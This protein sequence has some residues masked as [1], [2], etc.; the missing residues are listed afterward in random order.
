MPFGLD[1]GAG[2]LVASAGSPRGQGHSRRV[3]CG[4][5]PASRSRVDEVV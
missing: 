2:S 1:Q 3:G 4:F 5:R